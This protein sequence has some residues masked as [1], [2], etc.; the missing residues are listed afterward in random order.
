MTAPDTSSIAAGSAETGS[1]MSPTTQRWLGSGL[2]VLGPVAAAH[3]TW[4]WS[5]TA[6]LLSSGTRGGTPTHWLWLRFE[7][8]PAAGLLL[9]VL[10]AAVAGS[11]V[12]TGMVFANR[13]GH[14]TLEQHW[15]WWYVLRP[16]CAPCIGLL[17]YATVFAGL[18]GGGAPEHQDLALAGAIGGL[19][20]LFHD[21]VLALLR[22]ALGASAFNVSASL[23]EQAALTG[24]VTPAP[25]TA[26]SL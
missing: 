12:V 19:A 10:F 8:S 13:A 21:R 14:G 25:S 16:G 4:A 1:S 24:G 5:T 7:L 11:V 2:A 22:G 20:G 15:A 23:P 3:L 18:F 9:V 26:P 17:L 6:R